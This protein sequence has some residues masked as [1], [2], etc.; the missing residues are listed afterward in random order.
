MGRPNA[1]GRLK[2]KPYGALLAPL[3]Y[4]NPREFK[5]ACNSLGRGVSNAQ[6]QEP[7]PEPQADWMP[8]MLSDAEI[9][10]RVQAGE[11]ELFELLIRRHNM[12]LFRTIRSLLLDDAEA[13]DALQATYLKAWQALG[14]FAQRSQFI[15]WITRIALRE[16]AACAA[17][18][19]RNTQIE[20][21]PVQDG[22]AEAYGGSAEHELESREAV[23]LLER[24]IDALPESY[25]QV[26]V[27]CAVQEVPADEVASCLG[28]SI[29]NVRVRLHRAR[30]MLQQRLG[31]AA[32]I[33][34]QPSRAWAFAGE[35]CQRMVEAVMSQI[36]LRKNP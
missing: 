35:R 7:P 3:N 4:K 23:R 32:L 12:R 20:Q 6:M 31:D 17:K 11:V 5:E 28:V 2:V 33:G 18:R 24:H 1:P 19:Q 34:R 30:N 36:G 13:E 21:L 16:A 10:S 9:V 27:L 22:G 14:A 25:R 15:T 26:F 8:E 29:S